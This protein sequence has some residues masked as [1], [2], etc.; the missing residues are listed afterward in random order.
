MV[1]D[2][3]ARRF[4]EACRNIFAYCDLLNFKP[5]HQQGAL[6]SA[7]QLEAELP[8]QKRL[9]RFAVKSG[10]GPGKTAAAGVVGSW[11][12]L[13]R[14]KGMSVVTAPTQRQV[15]DV[16]MAELA[17]LFSKADPELQQLVQIDAYRMRVAETRDWEIKA[18]TSNKPENVQGYHQPNLTFIFD[19][20]SGIPRPIWEV[21]LN[22]LTNEDSLLLAIGNPNESDTAFH[23]CFYSS[24]DLWH[25]FTWNAEEAP[26]VDKNNLK[27]IEQEFGR[28]SD[29][30]RVRVLGEFPRQ[31]PT[32]IMS[33]EDLL[34]CTKN[35]LDVCALEPWGSMERAFG[36]DLARF[37]SDESVICV[38]RGRAML[39]MEVF[40]K[41]EP[42]YVLQRAMV[43]QNDLGW[44]NEKCVYVVDASGPGQGAM[45]LLH[46]AKKR[47][48]EFYS[49]GTP[50]NPRK[51]KDKI[52]EAWF[53]VRD[54]VKER[55]GHL[56]KDRRTLHQL[57]NRKFM[58][59]KG[60]I[61]IESKDEYK[62]RIGTDE[63]TSPDR[64]D[65]TILAFYPHPITETKIAG[66]DQ[67]KHA[68]G[69]RLAGRA[70]GGY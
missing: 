4:K 63:A 11:R 26:H 2:R 18:V 37:G 9:K 3:F 10:Q 50:R 45:Y 70:T 60:L 28:D 69:L 25:T 29:V 39:K 47:V 15:R 6:F 58:M 46:E 5:T 35:R 65:G 17:R 21:V 68:L 38:R 55:A 19:E 61:V 40:V 34:A 23:D 44:P 42:A 12:C 13:R 31:D 43:I 53:D 51:F 67:E 41:K 49:Q 62:K 22:T 48:L 66:M 57:G 1:S 8:P 64:A 14:H 56:P 20:A 52:S 24:S 54:L 7:I 36:I 33:S 32:S 59:K 16:Y 27:R 30:Y